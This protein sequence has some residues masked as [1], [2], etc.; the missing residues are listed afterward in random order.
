MIWNGKSGE[1]R[2]NWKALEIDGF[3][4][5]KFLIIIFGWNMGWDDNDVLSESRKI[6][7]KI[8]SLM[9]YG[10]LEKLFEGR[11]HLKKLKNFPKR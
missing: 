1:E 5:F 6:I 9:K 8:I 4:F 3:E 2:K 10:F 11:R 7:I